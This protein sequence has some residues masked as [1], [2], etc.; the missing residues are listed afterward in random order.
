MHDRSDDAR[1]TAC[2]VA[3]GTGD[4]AALAEFVRRTQR[5]VHRFLTHLASPA[6][7][8][9][10]AQETYLRA[11]RALPRFEA[12][13]PA[14]TWLLAIARH[15][16]VD[17]V[18]AAQRRP[19]TDGVDDWEAVAAT[20]R[21]GAVRSAADEA[22]V[23]R[24]LVDALDTDRREAFVLTQLLDLSYAEAAEVCGCPVGTIRSRVARAREDLVEA[25]AGTPTDR[26]AEA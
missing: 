23:L 6:E 25:M 22:I 9:D 14:R 5:D 15:V 26:Q 3:A 20:A 13:S 2:A 11:L 12:R 8:D 1:T 4:R 18:R 21:P 19:R 17:A 7:A 16:A 24:A 10:L